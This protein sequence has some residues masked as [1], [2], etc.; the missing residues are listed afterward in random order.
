[1]P[2]ANVNNLAINYEIHGE[3][4]PI[5]LISGMTMNLIPWTPYQ[6]QA[7]TEAGYKVIV[8]DNRDVGKT[9]E[10]SIL[11]YTIAQLSEDTFGL[12][13]QL[14][15]N[16]AHVIGY[17]MGGTI[18]LDMAIRKP[19]RVRTITTLGSTSKQCQ[20]ERNLLE[21][22]KTAK[23]KMSVN[24]FWQ[25]MGSK[26]MTWKFFE[27]QDAVERWF[28]FVTSD[29]NAQSAVALGRQADACANFDVSAELS[30]IKQPAHIVV[31]EDDIMLPVRHS[32]EI[33]NGIG[34]SVLTVLPEAAHAAYSEAA[35]L[36]NEKVIEFI[37]A[38]DT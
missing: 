20:F 23:L 10:S 17:S 37:N 13:D 11:E 2:T 35:P 32:R 30:S 21:V 26:V 19:D 25:F 29:M 34:N 38:V 3:R 14:Q 6:V 24:E 7:L 1:M 9:G 12:L 27:N 36:F 16:S 8:F 22:V 4:I 18:A 5:V 15:I 31:G 33:A 28:G